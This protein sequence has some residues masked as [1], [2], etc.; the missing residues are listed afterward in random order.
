[1]DAAAANVGLRLN[2]HSLETRL[3]SYCGAF[4]IVHSYVCLFSP[5]RFAFLCSLAIC[6]QHEA[7][8]QLKHLRLWKNAMIHLNFVSLHYYELC[9]EIR[10]DHGV[11]K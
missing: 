2:P 3:Q 10:V 1:M 5:I 8:G 11:R 6:P 7:Q 4:S 9:P